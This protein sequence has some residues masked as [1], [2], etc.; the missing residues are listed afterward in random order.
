M[1]SVKPGA[2]GTGLSSPNISRPL[3]LGT[4]TSCS[5]SWHPR[6]MRTTLM[7]DSGSPAHTAPGTSFLRRNIVERAH[8]AGKLRNGRTCPVHRGL[9]RFD[10]PRHRDLHSLARSTAKSQAE[11][12]RCDGSPCGEWRCGE[13]RSGQT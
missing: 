7:A 4:L 2:S 13:R 3:M 8:D 10:V 5:V 12:A 11:S 6:I 9:E 1:G